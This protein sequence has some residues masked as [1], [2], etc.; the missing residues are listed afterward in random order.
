MGGEEGKGSFGSDNVMVV[1][2]DDE[3]EAF[4]R[5][6]DWLIECEEVTAIW[7]CGWALG[8]DGKDVATRSKRAEAIDES[9]LQQSMA[10]D[11]LGAPELGVASV[12]PRMLTIEFCGKQDGG[13]W[14][15]RRFVEE[16]RGVEERWS[17]MERCARSARVDLESGL[18]GGEGR[19]KKEG[20]RKRKEKEGRKKKKEEGRKRKEGKR[21]QEEGRKRKEEEGRKEGRRQEEK[22]KKEETGRKKEESARVDFAK[23]MKAWMMKEKRVEMKN[24]KEDAMVACLLA[25]LIYCTVG[26]D[27][28]LLREEKKAITI[29]LRY[30]RRLDP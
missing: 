10:P 9:T 2:T 15:G 8:Q 28:Y 27:C 4:R 5:F 25:Y 18:E 1:E 7:A 20:R 22:R 26:N 6:Q 30:G 17:E 23:E 21:K 19:K 11:D 16:G 12:R 29:V 14:Q 13:E 3:D 24:K